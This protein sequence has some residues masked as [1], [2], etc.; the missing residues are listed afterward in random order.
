MS[1]RL[2]SSVEESDPFLPISHEISHFPRQTHFLLPTAFSLSPPPN[3]KQLQKHPL[4]LSFSSTLLTQSLWRPFSTLT[5]SPSLLPNLDYVTFL[6]TVD[7]TFVH[8]N[9]TMLKQILNKLPRK[10]PKSD[11]SDSAQS[12]SGSTTFGNVFQCTNV[13]VAIS[14]KLNVVRRVSSAVFPASLSAGMEAVDPHTS[15]K[16]VLNTH[17]QN[18]FIS[19]LNLC[20]RV[21]DTS[22]PDKNCIEKDVKRQ[23]LLE[24]VDFVSSGSAKFTEPAIAAMC[25]MCACNLFRVFPPKFHTSTTGGE[26]EDE[27]P[28]FDP[29]WSHLQ[30]VYDLLLQFINYNALDLKVAKMHID[31]AF[32]VRLL[33]L[34]DSE[35][36]R[37]RDCLKTILHRIYGKFM[38]H[39]P[40]IRKS[41][42]N[43]IYHFVFE[44]E[45]HNGI[46]ELLEIFGS[47]ISGF[48]LPLKEEHK[49]ILCRAL[50]PLHKPKS[51]GIYHQWL[52][53]CVVQF[54]DKDPTLASTVIMGLLKYWPVT[55]SQKELMFISEIE[56]VLEVTSMAEF[57]KIMVPLFRRISCCL[58]SYHYQVA[59]RAHSLWNNGHILD[60]ITQNRQVVLPIVLSALVHNSQNHWNQAVLNQTQNI[61]KMLSQMDEDLV[62][63]CQH[64]LEEEDSRTSAAAERRR[65][66]WERLE[67]AANVQSVAVG[68]DVPVSIKSP[69]CYVAC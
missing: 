44:T 57:Q 43:I 28:M 40:F 61:R 51:V 23:T 18:L 11:M 67:A 56:E 15:F 58:N 1:H 64:K 46:A 66:T 39:R 24:L 54:I 41:V 55:N 8:I 3:K 29:A 65:I 50:I 20:C 14:N 32:I 30:I 4:P 63:A 48:A 6:G 16:D 33:D 13:G 69:A 31:Q 59:E 38:V 47:V 21:Y 2:F 17:K 52:T 60:L 10:V 22:D 34:S 5:S 68:G 12:D 37:E 49:M 62:L 45:H 36:S 53:Y 27:E 26:T 25:K 42:S 19:K 35:D 9:S 7:S